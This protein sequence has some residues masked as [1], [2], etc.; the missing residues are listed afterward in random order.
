MTAPSITSKNIHPDAKCSPREKRLSSD[1]QPAAQTP[2]ISSAGAFK[3]A[4]GTMVRGIIIGATVVITLAWIAMLVW[5][6]ISL[7]RLI[8]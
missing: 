7:V 8:I 5:L 1:A 3:R 4:V 6:T 2:P